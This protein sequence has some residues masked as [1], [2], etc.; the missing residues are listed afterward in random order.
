MRG[1]ESTTP[2]TQSNTNMLRGQQLEPKARR[3]YMRTAGSSSTVSTTGL[4]IHASGKIAASPD[5][6]M[7]QPEAPTG[8]LEIKVPAAGTKGPGLTSS[9][10][11]QIMVQLACT[12]AQFA[13]YVTLYE[14]RPGEFELG[15]IRI[16]RD[17]ALIAV[18]MDGLL[19]FYNDVMQDDKPPEVPAIDPRYNARLTLAIRHCFEEHISEERRFST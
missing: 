18:I 10:L 4:Y 17:D 6:L 11:A 16:D 3:V 13:D 9:Q 15:V 1:Q 12:G 14:Y 7:G 5:V 19:E 2:A 8:L